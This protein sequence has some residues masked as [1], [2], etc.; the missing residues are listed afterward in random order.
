M[1]ILLTS[2]LHWLPDSKLGNPADWVREKWTFTEHL[3]DV[4][5]FL[6]TFT[7]IVLFTSQ[8]PLLDK[9]TQFILIKENFIKRN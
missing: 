1:V 3:L 6:G 7:H 4:S 9:H 8:K 2:Y 5:Y